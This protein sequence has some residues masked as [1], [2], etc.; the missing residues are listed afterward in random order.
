MDLRFA[1]VLRSPPCTYAREPLSP[2]FARQERNTHHHRA[3]VRWRRLAA[4]RQAMASKNYTVT[5]GWRAAMYT[6]GYSDTRGHRVGVRC[7]LWA[8][9]NAPLWIRSRTCKETHNRGESVLDLLITLYIVLHRD[10][11]PRLSLAH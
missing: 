10:S 5:A 8:C 3:T 1:R 6:L 4:C 11:A 2:L 7:A 9:A